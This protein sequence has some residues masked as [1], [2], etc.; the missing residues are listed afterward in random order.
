MSASQR[1]A[2]ALLIRQ[3]VHRLPD[4][5]A[6]IHDARLTGAALGAM[7]F[8]WA[9]GIERREP[10]YYRIQGPHLL[11]EYDDTQDDANHIHAVWRDPESDFGSDLLA[12]H[13]RHAH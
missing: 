5:L 2:L 9:G 12:E 8:A 4:E 13:Y 3:Y 11:I 10:H 6:A 7:H 1:E